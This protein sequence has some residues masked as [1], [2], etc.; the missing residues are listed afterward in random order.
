LHWEGLYAILNCGHRRQFKLWRGVLMRFKVLL[1]VLCVI[2]AVG[3]VTTSLAS[4]FTGLREAQ[5]S[6]ATES[7]PPD[8][9]S[10]LDAKLLE[11][12]TQDTILRQWRLI[13]QEVVCLAT[14]ATDTYYSA[15][16]KI[17][18]VHTL[19]CASA[20]DWPAVRGRLKF[21][22]D[23]GAELTQGQRALLQRELDLWVTEITEYITKPQECYDLL[24]LVVLKEA[25]PV[26]APSAV[27]VFGE[28][29]DGRFIPVSHDQIP[30]VLE[31]EGVAYS[32]MGRLIQSPGTASGETTILSLY[33]RFAATNY[34]VIY[35]STATIHHCALQEDDT[36]TYQDTDYYSPYFDY[37]CDTDCAN[38]VSQALNYGGIPADDTWIPYEDAWVNVTYLLNYMIENDYC[39]VATLGTCVAGYPIKIGSGHV[40][41]M[42]YNDGVTEK[43]TGHTNDR[44]NAA[45]YHPSDAVYYRVIY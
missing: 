5:E 29:P 15:S 40:V 12:L 21:L 43:Y 22:S 10:V 35:S 19:N 39:E 1:A 23:R 11:Y 25:T 18:R 41:L 45:W 6:E 42:T 16:Y 33:D 28:G 8:A 27:R 31:A 37:Y 38:F 2:L 44:K 24:K 20:L 9:R 34:A 4:G 3:Y 36:R 26:I 30:S 17:R 32:S 13:S 7:L 14:Q